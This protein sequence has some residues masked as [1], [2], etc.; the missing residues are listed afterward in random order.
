MFI[1]SFTRTHHYLGCFQF[2]VP[3]N[4]AAMRIHYKYFLGHKFS[5]LLSKYLRKDGQGHMIKYVQLYKKL[6]NCSQTWSCHFISHHTVMRILISF[7]TSLPILY[8]T[9]PFNF[10]HSICL[11]WYFIIILT[12]TSLMTS[13]TEHFFTWLLAICILSFVKLVYFICH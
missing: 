13:D 11:K 12:W 10:S 8:I 4:K 2:W 3:I 7:S 1:Q 9:N 5:F 6:A